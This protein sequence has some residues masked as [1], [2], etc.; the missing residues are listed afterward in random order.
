VTGDGALVV[1]GD[2][3]LD[4]D[5]NGHASR[6][7]PDAPVPVL[8]D[9][10]E[11]RRPGGA[12]LAALL[13]ALDG[14]PVV[15]LAPF[16]DDPASATVRS[17]L[18]PWLSVVPLPLHGRLQ[19]KIRFRA[20]GQV[21]L[22]VDSPPGSAGPAGPEAA[23]AIAGAGGLLVSDYGRGL[24]ADPR[25]RRWLAARARQVPLVWDPHPHGTD[26]VPGTRVVT[27]NHREAAAAAGQGL[28]PQGPVI[29]SAAVAA[30]RLLSQW[31]VDAV[32]VTLGAAGAL[33]AAQGTPAPLVV[34]AGPA[35]RADTCGAGDRF[36]AAAAA[37]LRAGALLSEAITEATAAASEFLARGGVARLP[38]PQ[39][40]PAPAAGRPGAGRPAGDVPPGPAADPD[41]GTAEEA[42]RIA[43]TVRRGGGT[44]VA[45]GGCFDVLHAGHISMLAAARALGDCLIV[46]LNSDASVRRLKGDGRPLNIA[47]DRAAVLTALECVDGVMIFDE[48]TPAAA[49][50]RLR[51]GVW[52]KGGDY[53]GQDLPEAAVLG[54]WGGQA[55]TVPYLDGRSTTGLFTAT[56]ALDEP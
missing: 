41:A 48:D 3:L 24:T 27:P 6:L 7:V 32:A 51:P 54:A 1:V 36:S 28:L 12:A 21:L 4:R 20:S 16:G 19:E 49:L 46:C 26:P 5:V 53:S 35:G 2:A 11:T 10:V 37:A 47:A 17:L 42:L 23:D 44:V 13:A 33:L 43:G 52:V 56:M 15:L 38:Q 39:A 50:R 9:V 29:K 8:D 25:L 14:T 55:V 18:E 31:Q 34:P 40:G 22:R 30:Q 45:T